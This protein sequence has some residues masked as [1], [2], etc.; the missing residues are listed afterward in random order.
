M[1]SERVSFILHALAPVLLADDT[2]PL[3][4][5]QAME[6]GFPGLRLAWTISAEGFV[7]APEG[8]ARI[9]AR[10]RAGGFALYSNGND[11]HLVTITGR[12]MPGALCPGGKPLLDVYAKWPVDA[13]GLAAAVDVLEGV[14]EAAGSYWGHVTPTNATTAIWDQISHTPAGPTKSP[15]GLPMLKRSSELPS[16]DHPEYL[17][18]LNYW[19]AAA[20]RAIGFPDPTRDAE[21][22]SRSR[23]TATGG[24]VVRLTDTPLDLDSPGHID[25]LKSAYERFPKI[26]GRTSP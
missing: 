5:I 9:I 8:D 21:L 19:S 7:P 3:A 10:T 14:A 13:A 24:W 23:G 25:A 2:R 12:T 18:W 22:L 16:P 15:R 6:R 4:V 11:A 17:G 1:S 26:G 20:A